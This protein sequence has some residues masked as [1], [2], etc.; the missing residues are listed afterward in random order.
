MM[1]RLPGGTRAPLP[2]PGAAEALVAV[3]PASATAA[4]MPVEAAMNCLRLRPRP[5]ASFSGL[6]SLSCMC[7]CSLRDDRDGHAEAVLPNLLS[8]QANP[9]LRTLQD[10]A[11]DETREPST[12]VQDPDRSA[13]A[14]T[15]DRIR[16]TWSPSEKLGRGSAPSAMAVRKSTAWWVKPCS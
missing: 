8:G 7:A 1:P 12:G 11:A 15:A 13:L 5:L 4:A 2:V 14:S 9:D 6:T 10:R 16:C 3:A